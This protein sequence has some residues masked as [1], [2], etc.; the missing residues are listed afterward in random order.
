MPVLISDRVK[1]HPPC[2]VID[3]DIGCRMGEVLRVFFR[4][5]IVSLQWDSRRSLLLDFCMA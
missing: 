4:V 1:G 2:V 5:L 3:G